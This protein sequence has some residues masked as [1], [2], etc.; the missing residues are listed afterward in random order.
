MA[1]YFV[2]LPAAQMPRNAMLDLSSVDNAL[3]NYQDQQNRNRQFG[4]QEQQLGMD[5]ERLGLAK[6]ADA[7]ANE[8]QSFQRT[9]RIAQKFGAIS[10]VIAD[11]PNPQTAQANWSRTLQSVPQLS[12]KL[13]EYG[14]NPSDYRTATRF[15]MAEAGKYKT[16]AER[17]REA[18]QMQVL[19]RQA[20]A[21]LPDP[22]KYMEANDGNIL[23]IGRGGQADVVYR[24]GAKP[25]P[26][27]STVMS[28]IAEADQ[29]AASNKSAIDTL[30]QAIK[31]NSSANAGVG[32]GFRAAIANNLP[33]AV[34]PDMISSPESGRATVDLDNLVTTQAL[35]TLRSTFGGNPT[36]GERQILLDVAGSVSQP[37][38]VRA[39]IYRRAKEAAEARMVE[40][41]Q[42]ADALRRG[43][44]YTP[45]YQPG[46]PQSNLGG[47]QN[48]PAADMMSRAEAQKVVNGK[49]YIKI[50]GQWYDP[51]Q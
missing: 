13:Q 22:S 27:N 1:N 5:R 43:T 33:D 50:G 49:T 38:E 17:E 12:Q 10:Q 15:L 31:L 36:E 51:G 29:F 11:D 40:N 41:Q 7:R 30:D 25:A 34:V 46:K 16:N 8:D 47:T 6:N 23:R 18:L 32:A 26:M 4:M 37:R 14:I 24:G 2:N 44:Y 48:T 3:A 19:R 20:S 45:G 28:A 9:Q 35:Q 42:K 39:R 21:P